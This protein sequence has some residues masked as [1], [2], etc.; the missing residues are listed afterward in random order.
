MHPQQGG[1]YYSILWLL[2]L[3]WLV[4]SLGGLGWRA[5]HYV[6]RELPK[7]SFWVAWG[8]LVY[9]NS[10]CIPTSQTWDGHA[11]ARMVVD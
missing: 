4:F 3:L 5:F 9:V 1:S 11:L 7:G 6:I 10:W 2:W 8:V